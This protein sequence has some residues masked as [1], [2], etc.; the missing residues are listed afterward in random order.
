MELD[1]IRRE[2]E[3]NKQDYLAHVLLEAIKLIESLI[4]E[5]DT[6]HSYHDRR[7]GLVADA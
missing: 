4:E 3:E 6:L 7:E 2:Y 5:I 1:E